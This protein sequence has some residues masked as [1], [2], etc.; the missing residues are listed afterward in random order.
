[1][2]LGMVVLHSTHPRKNQVG[3]REGRKYFEPSLARSASGKFIPARTLMMDSYCLKCH[4]DAYQGWFHSAHHFSSFNNQPYLFSVRET[5]RVAP[6]KDGNVKAARWCAGCHAL[7]PIFER[8]SAA[9]QF[10]AVKYPLSRGRIHCTAA[11]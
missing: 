9:P 2:V 5:R 3:S 11:P 8:A 1:I 4:Q 6:E 7:A 10:A